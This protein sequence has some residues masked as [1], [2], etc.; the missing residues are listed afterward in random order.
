MRIIVM[1]QR[2]HNGKNSCYDSICGI[3]WISWFRKVLR[4]IGRLAYENAVLE[5]LAF[6]INGDEDDYTVVMVVLLV[7][8]CIRV[9]VYYHWPRCRYIN[10]LFPFYLLLKL[11][12]W[13]FFSFLRWEAYFYFKDYDY[14]VLT[15]NLSRSQGSG[16]ANLWGGTKVFTCRP[17]FPAVTWGFGGARWA[18]PTGSVLSPN[19]KV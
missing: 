4:Q 2:I 7:R 6:P 9:I 11:N 19:R 15:S 17:T 10:R 3:A 14:F 8:A 5:C 13:H 16:I 12:E 1:H 18:L